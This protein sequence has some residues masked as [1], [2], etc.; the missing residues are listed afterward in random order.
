MSQ[1]LTSLVISSMHTSYLPV[2]TVSD[3]LTSLAYF[4]I[5]LSIL[6]FIK[7]RRDLKFKWMYLCFTLFILMC[8]I[9]HLLHVLPHIFATHQFYTLQSIAAALTATI[10]IIT[11]I[12]IWT[13]IPKLL[14]I[15]T[16]EEL[17]KANNEILYLAHYDTLTGLINRNNF[18]TLMEQEITQAMLNGKKLAVVFIDL[19]RFKIINDTFGHR[20][21]DLLLEEAAKRLVSSVGEKDIVSRQ[22]GDEFILLLQDVSCDEIEKTVNNILQLMST[23]FILDGK[24]IYCTPSMGISS[25]PSDGRDAES[26]IKYADLAMYRAKESGRNNYKFFTEAMNDEISTKL[27]LEN[28]LRKALLRNELEVYYQPQLD[29]K[30][31][32]IIAMEALLRWHHPE[33]GFMSPAEFIPLAEETGLIVPIGKWV[34]E[35]ACKQTQQWRNQGH[36]LSVSVNISN[37]QLVSNTIVGKIKEITRQA[38][39]DPQYLTL[40]ITESM[41]ITNLTDTLDKLKQLQDFGVTIALDDFG[42][43]YSSLS[44][45]SSLP[46]DFV[47][48]DKSFVNELTNETKKEIVRSVSNIAKSLG[49]KVVAEGVEDK[50]QY[51]IIHSLGIEVIQGYYISKP[52]PKEVL[53]AKFLVSSLV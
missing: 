35:E 5:P 38:K 37:H 31:N 33:K 30:T 3:L 43:G 24:E 14:K 18:N 52:I 2:Q 49:L 25:Y 39:L 10:S 20:M 11:A 47:K 41:A 9:T 42:T 36:D 53:E 7:K 45:L 13:V 40:E 1:M 21:G 34:L 12:L 8:G 6:Y 19:D 23:P 15:P 48:I 29:L 26:L 22:G 46:I 51:H 27:L 28:D 16:A 4:T 44:Y 32:K 50:Q 17:E